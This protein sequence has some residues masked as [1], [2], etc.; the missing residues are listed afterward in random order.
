MRH[1]I[2]S[3]ATK[4]IALALTTSFL[5]T[6]ALPVAQAEARDGRH[7]RNHDARPV[8][9]ERRGNNGD[10][11]AAGVIGFA[12]GALIA[13]QASRPRTV[14]VEREPIYERP[15]RIYVQPEPV[16]RQPLAD[17]QRPREVY[18]EPV[19][20][21]YDE[22]RVIRYDDTVNASY[23]PWTQEWA[24]WCSNKYRSFNVNTGTYRGY[25]SKDHFCVVQ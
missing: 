15:E 3:T 1:S 2:K 9:R 17:Y 12:I 7:W 21:D 11:L 13:D 24:N 6:A 23:E 4:A 10:A 14:Y 8:Y 25:D 19:R 22:P 5:A 20:N 16:Y 18:R